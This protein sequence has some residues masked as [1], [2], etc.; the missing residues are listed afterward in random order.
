[1]PKAG[2]WISSLIARARDGTSS[3]DGGVAFELRRAPN[4]PDRFVQLD[5]NS[6]LLVRRMSGGCPTGDSASDADESRRRRK[7]GSDTGGFE[8]RGG[9][10]G[11]VG[12]RPGEGGGGGSRTD[13]LFAVPERE[14]CGT[15]RGALSAGSSRLGLLECVGVDRVVGMSVSSLPFDPELSPR[16]PLS[17]CTR[18]VVSRRRLESRLP[19]RP[20]CNDPGVGTGIGRGAG[21]PPAASIGCVE[22][23]PARG[24]DGGGFASSRE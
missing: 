6:W 8:E 17:T 16:L 10:D 5:S 3:A 7:F 13:E 12:A 22:S 9:E 21:I 19:V 4:R 24:A 20:C 15:L 14:R 23:I 1:M 2:R 11:G 18:L